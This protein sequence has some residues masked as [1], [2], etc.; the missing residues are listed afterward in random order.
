[1]P[2]R[3]QRQW[4][5]VGGRS[6]GIIV[7]DAEKA[8]I[9][10]ACTQLIDTVIR[11]KHLP[12]VTPAADHNYPIAI[13]GKWSGNKFRFI[14]RWRV[15]DPNT[16]EFEIPWARIEYVAREHF[17]V[18]WRRHT[19]EWWRLRDHLTL[20]EALHEIETNPVFFVC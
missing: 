11:P 17:D 3:S 2:K 8:A 18:S 5:Y 16:E 15:R 10:V 20:A 9:T 13:Y 6:P 19:G 14:T 1:M 12:V 7:P 4:V